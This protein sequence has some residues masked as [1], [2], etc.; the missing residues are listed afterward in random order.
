MILDMAVGICIA[1]LAG[2]G[3][4]GGGLLVIWLVLLRGLPTQT[5]QGI[6]FVFF[7]VSALCALP[8]HLRRRTLC[9]RQILYLCI[10]ALPGVLIGCRLAAYIPAPAARRCFGYFLL[11]SG[12]MQLYRQIKTQFFS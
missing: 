9:M 3:I 10:T 8:V 2:M 4:G 11:L 1:A 6:N 7:L 12:A 5:A